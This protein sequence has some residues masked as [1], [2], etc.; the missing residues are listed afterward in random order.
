MQP[1]TSSAWNGLSTTDF[2]ATGSFANQE[3]EIIPKLWNIIKK[4]IVLKNIFLFELF[5]IFKIFIYKIIYNFI[6]IKNIKFI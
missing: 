5:K 6:K 2:T 3:I 1:V 4:W